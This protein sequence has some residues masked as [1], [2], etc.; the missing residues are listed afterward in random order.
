[1]AWETELQ[2][3]DDIQLPRDAEDLIRKLICGKQERLDIAQIKQHPFLASVDFANIRN[4]KS[5][6]PPKLSS[7][8]DTSYFPMEDLENVPLQI[9]DCD[10]SKTPQ[11]DEK[12]DLAFVG[13]TFKK[14]DFLTKRHAI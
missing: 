1:M 7:I 10:R 4:T 2:F 12:K 9:T 13:Y 6:F 8:T 11:G 3:P 5:P 14:F